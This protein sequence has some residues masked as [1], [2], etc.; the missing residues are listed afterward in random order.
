VIRLTGPG[1]TLSALIPAPASD[2][3]LAAQ[4]RCVELDLG[5][6]IVPAGARRVRLEA[7]RAGLFDYLELLR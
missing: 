2:I 1:L 7:S 6:V 4:A 3:P 5:M